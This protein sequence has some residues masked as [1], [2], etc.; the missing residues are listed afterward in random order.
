MR[1]ANRQDMFNQG[2]FPFLFFF[3]FAARKRNLA[4]ASI[5]RLFQSA[6]YHSEVLPGNFE[7][8]GIPNMIWSSLQK[9]QVRS[10]YTNNSITS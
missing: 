1:T 5:I 6:R 8:I 9:L 4:H 3:F 2:I 10:T 7:R